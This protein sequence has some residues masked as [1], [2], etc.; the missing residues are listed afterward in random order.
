MM[1][2]IRFN[3]YVSILPLVFVAVVAGGFLSFFETRE[4]LTRMSNRHLAYKAEQLRDYINNEWDT[5]ESLKLSDD[6]AYRAAERES[7]VTYAYSVLRTSSEA[8]YIFDADG[9]LSERIGG[10]GAAAESL[11]YPGETALSPPLTPGWFERTL[12]G[13]NRVGIAFLFEPF[14]W[15]IAISELRSL[16]FGD[17]NLV[18][19]DHIVVLIVAVVLAALLLAAY[20]QVII[21]P[22][23]RLTRN[24]ERIIA[25]G[26]FSLRLL[27]DSRDEIGVLSDRFNSLLTLVEDQK[28]GLIA[29]AATE[30]LA[31]AITQQREAETLLLLGHISE[32]NDEETGA[33]LF[34]LGTLSAT[35]SRLLGHDQENQD[36]MSKSAPLH[37]IGKIGVPQALLRKPAKLTDEEYEVMK[38]H[39]EYGYDLLKDCRSRYLLE[40]A[41]I[42][43]THH[44][45]W[46]GEG[47]PRGLA[48]EDIPLSGRIVSIVDVYDALVSDRP[49]KSAWTDEEALSFIKSQRGKKFD[50]ALVDI[51]VDHFEEFRTD[52]TG[53]AA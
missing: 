44:E 29:S 26:D 34:R 17:V 42:A 52:P 25:T 39:C 21:A 46:D 41:V 16:Y 2:G 15:T 48:G 51:F 10:T 4:A 24:I 8:I 33:H 18:F 13:E 22:L 14:G 1:N 50:P 36:L 38:R 28:G 11:S 3:T 6:A 20:L 19:R 49:Y 9:N 5:L 31:N 45:H 7:F 32:Y 30:R 37:D 43:W 23:E 40:G 47:Y 35:F 12:F 27:N 53:P